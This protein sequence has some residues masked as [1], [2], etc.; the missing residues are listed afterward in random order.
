VGFFG[1]EDGRM[2]EG[3]LKVLLA[4][5]EVAPFAKTGGLADVSGAL[6][7]AVAR[8]G[9]DVRV[10][11]PRYL[12][13]E[14]GGF[15]LEPVVARLAVPIADRVEES[16]LAV[17]RLDGGVPAYFLVNDRYYRREELYRTPQGD[18]EDNAERFIYFSRSIL[19]VLK[20]LDFAPDVIHCNDWQ[21]GLVPAYLKIL[22][23]TD[24]FFSRTATLFTIHNLAYQGLF[25]HFD[26]HLIGLSWDIFTPE[27]IEFYGKI[28]LM[29][30]GLVYSD[31]ITTVSQRYAQEIQTPEFGCG[32]EGVL[33]ARGEDLFGVLNG[34]DV[35]AWNPATDPH[36]AAP[37]H[38]GD[39]SGKRK[40]KQDLLA[41]YRLPA[42]PDLPL[43]GCVTRLTE[44]KGVDLLLQ[45]LDRLM[46]LDCRLVILGA[47]DPASEATLRA[48]AAR[49]PERLGVRIGFDEALAH[50]IEG[51][52][53]MFLMPSRFEP[54]GLS[55]MYSLRYGTV[56]IVRATGGLADTVRNY[57]PETGNGTGLSFKGYSADELLQAIG[58]AL[59]VYRDP[60]AW[61]RL[62]LNG[63]ALDFSWEA[64]AAEYVRLYRRAVERRTAGRGRGA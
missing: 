49:R 61:R 7:R 47:G 44:Q 58:R 3:P 48:A 10:I 56:P 46:A 9:H 63:M 29:K 13:V 35:A 8:L 31:L 45:S 12:A 36:L 23:G 59:A 18:Y 27:G 25:W 26:M 14:R 19:E 21:T 40:C 54:C 24:P 53:D 11:M 30:A 41:T 17:G 1:V 42:E 64:S 16:G 43:L 33:R 28:N 4:A 38:A 5:S 55:Q 6:A 22:H 20:A 51:G 15:T 60:A 37:Y 2:T 57:N 62:M 34:I 32:L 39:L 50:K 52:A